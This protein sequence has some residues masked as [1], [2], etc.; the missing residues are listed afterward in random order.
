MTAAKSSIVYRKKELK[1][2]VEACGTPM[3]ADG[4]NIHG[5]DYHLMAADI[6]KLSDDGSGSCLP[7]KLRAAGVDFACPTLFITECVLVYLP[8]DDAKA[9]LRFCR[10]SFGAGVFVNYEPIL[11]H[12]AFGRTMQNNLRARGCP[13]LGIEAVPTLDAQVSRF[14]DVGCSGATA[15]D[16]NTV[17]ERCI[18][19]AEEDRVRRIEMMDEWEE[20]RL[21][22][23]HYCLSWAWW[24]PP[25]TAAD[26]ASATLNLQNVAL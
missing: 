22:L 13:F 16:M 3:K 26:A 17:S 8:P 23:A 20:A 25:A 2:L 1:A 19:Q 21:M 10:D 6:R 9:L 24:Q 18:S 5:G 15:I 4:M 11:P 7:A 12:D 14:L